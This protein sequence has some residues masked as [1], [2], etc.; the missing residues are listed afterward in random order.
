MTNKNNSNFKFFLLFF[1]PL[2]LYNS[3]GSTN[4]LSGDEITTA[5]D[6]SIRVYDIKEEIPEDAIFKKTIEDKQS[7]NLVDNIY[8]KIMSRAKKECKAVGANL[9]KITWI[10]KDAY[11]PF[12]IKADLYFSK[13]LESTPHTDK[14]EE[15]ATIYFYRPDYTRGALASYNVLDQ[16]GDFICNLKNNDKHK[17]QT[18]EFDLIKLHSNKVDKPELEID[19]QKGGVYYVKC[20]FTTEGLTKTRLAMTLIQDNSYGRIEYLSTEIKD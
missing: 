13:N 11:L 3:C 17:Y 12:K 19:L 20:Y 15:Y 9:I 6:E 2:F 16:S 18:K 14:S 7:G 4:S 8:Y 10:R 5:L 1:I